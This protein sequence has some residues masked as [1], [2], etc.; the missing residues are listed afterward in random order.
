VY[1]RLHVG[2]TVE[3]DYSPRWHKLRWIRRLK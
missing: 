3:V 1:K 2:D